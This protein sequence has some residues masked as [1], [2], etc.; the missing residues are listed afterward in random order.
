V[1]VFLVAFFMTLVYC[2]VRG[3]DNKMAQYTSTYRKK[4]ARS[5]LESEG[6]GSDNEGDHSK[7]RSSRMLLSRTF[8]IT[9]IET[10]NEQRRQRRN[11]RSKA[12]ANQ[13]LFYA[14]TFAMVWLF[15][16]I[17]RG[18]QLA[19]AKPPWAI[20]FLF[21]VFT[22]SQGFFNF[23]VFIRP[24]LIKYFKK[25]KKL[26]EGRMSDGKESSSMLHVSGISG[27]SGASAGSQNDGTGDKHTRDSSCDMRL[28]DPYISMKE[29]PDENDI[30]SFAKAIPESD[31]K[32]DVVSF[33]L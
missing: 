7:R 20:I 9:K 24:R 26:R 21:A 2:Y 25:R 29:T 17:V 11:E 10:L 13:G 16:T 3:L 27:L 15:G 19:G 18:M 5:S 1:C 12:V 4:A 8:S 28:S 14:G 33:S 6:G 32:T 22:P 31:S 30:D 23:L